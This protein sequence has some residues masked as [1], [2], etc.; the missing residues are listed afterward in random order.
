MTLRYSPRAA[1]ALARLKSPYNDIE[2]F[3]E[4]TVNA[5]MWL[6]LI[7]AVPL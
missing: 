3:V 7:R 4:D 1:R 2:I 6:E 5:N